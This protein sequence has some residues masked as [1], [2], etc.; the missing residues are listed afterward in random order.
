[1]PTELSTF[2]INLGKKELVMLELTLLNEESQ[3]ACSPDNCNPDYV[4]FCP[5]DDGMCSPD[6]SGPA[7]VPD[8]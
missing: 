7:C 6:L 5:P 3:N 1:M 4:G 2:R 8:V